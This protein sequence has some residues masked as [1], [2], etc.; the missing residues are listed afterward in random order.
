M[1]TEGTRRRNRNRRIRKKEQKFLRARHKSCIDRN[2][3]VI[4]IVSIVMIFLFCKLEIENILP[5]NKGVKTSAF[6]Y[7]FRS[8]KTGDMAV[9]EFKVDK[10]RY[11]GE[12]IN[13]KLGDSIEVLYLPQN[14]EINRNAK[15]INEDWCVWLYRKIFE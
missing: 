12:S 10:E 14:P 9:Y 11:T 6:V 2:R 3:F 1:G 15:S 5:Y 7:K 8:L 4:G 13:G